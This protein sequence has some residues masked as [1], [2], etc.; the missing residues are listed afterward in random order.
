[1]FEA[2]KWP[3]TRKALEELLAA[4]TTEEVCAAARDVLGRMPK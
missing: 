3:E 1:M 4:C 2:R